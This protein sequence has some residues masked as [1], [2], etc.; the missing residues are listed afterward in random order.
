ML[1]NTAQSYGS[2][3]KFFH[4]IIALLIIGL[5]FVGYFMGGI[6][7]KPTRISI[8]NA[9]KLTGLTVLALMILRAGWALI[10]PKPLLPLATPTWERVLV[11]CAHLLL[12]AFVIAMPLSGWIGSVAAGYVPHFAN[13]VFNLPITPDPALAK[14]AFLAHYVL[15]IIIIVFVVLH[16]VAAL[17]HHYIKRDDILRR[18]VPF[19][20]Q[21]QT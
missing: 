12:Y 7:D 19:G 1:R 8:I 16:I 18:M 21:K 13:Y 14:L 10:N 9:H 5:V 11:R 3:A 6:S 15:A 20:R 2:I 17:Y 4:W